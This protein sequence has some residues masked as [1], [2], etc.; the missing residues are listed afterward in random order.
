MESGGKVAY[1][2]ARAMID[3]GSSVRTTME[4]SLKICSGSAMRSSTSFS[5]LNLDCG[6]CPGQKPVNARKIEF[7]SLVPVSVSVGR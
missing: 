3:V 7:L 4:A 5:D 1:F 6:V 2:N